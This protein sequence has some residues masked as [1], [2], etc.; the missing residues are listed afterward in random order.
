MPQ[1]LLWTAMLIALLRAIFWA[2]AEFR[3]R[4]EGVERPRLGRAP[5]SDRVSIAVLG[6][7]LVVT[8]LLSVAVGTYPVFRYWSPVVPAILVLV[9][10]AIPPAATWPAPVTRTVE[11]P[12]TVDAD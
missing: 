1:L 12:A 10:L 6:S 9:A 8:S 7:L 4:S 5:P 11:V 2:L 3:R